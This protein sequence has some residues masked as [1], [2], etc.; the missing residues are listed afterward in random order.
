[1]LVFSR[2]GSYGFSSQFFVFLKL[3]F[4]A[5]LL[6]AIFHLVHDVEAIHDIML[7]ANSI[8]KFLKYE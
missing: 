2:R 4:F 6:V 3:L 7:T 1:M 8:W 5:L